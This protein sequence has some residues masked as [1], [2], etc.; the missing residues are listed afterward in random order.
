MINPAFAFGAFVFFTDGWLI[1]PG[2]G[3][4]I[5][6]YIATLQPGNIG[7]DFSQNIF[8]VFFG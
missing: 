8:H 7:L 1:L 4:E 5:V 6:W 3:F 2:C